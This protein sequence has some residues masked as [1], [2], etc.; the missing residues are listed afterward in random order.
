MMQEVWLAPS[1]AP[2]LQHLRWQ[3]GAVR[4]LSG[5]PYGG[6]REYYGS[7]QGRIQEG[8]YRLLPVKIAP[9]EESTLPLRINILTMLDLCHLI[10]RSVSST[11]LSRPYQGPLSHM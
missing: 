3:R 7:E 2:S 6:F 9:I 11:G 4:S 10:V 8:S 1:L 5:R